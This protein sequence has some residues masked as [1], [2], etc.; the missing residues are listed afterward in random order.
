VYESEK[1]ESVS[2]ILLHICLH[3]TLLVHK[4][5]RSRAVAAFALREVHACE[6]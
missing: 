5:P 4:P 2:A 6:D 3:A 1:E